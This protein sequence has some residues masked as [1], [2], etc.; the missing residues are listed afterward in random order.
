MINLLLNWGT[1]LN[2]QNKEGMTAL[3]FAT[4]NKDYKTVKL[5]LDHGANTNTRNKEGMTALL[6]SN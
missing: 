2:I 6:I 1:D 5:L 4:T 3:M